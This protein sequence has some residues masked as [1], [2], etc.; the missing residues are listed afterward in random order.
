MLLIRRL[1]LGAAL[2]AVL[3]A[4]STSITI[5][6]LPAPGSTVRTTLTQDLHFDVVAPALPTPILLEGSTFARFVLRTG[7][8]DSLGGMLADLTYDTLATSITMNGNPMGQP[9]QV[10]GQHITA[11]YD[12]AGR[13]VDLT[14]P[15][16]MERYLGNIRQLQS[17]AMSSLP[18]G[19]LSVGDS[20][21]TLFQTP[22]PLDIGM[23]AGDSVA[24]DGTVIHRLRA[25]RR[26]SGQVIAVFDQLVQGTVNREVTMPMLGTAHVTL[27]MTGNGVLEIDV[28]NSLVRSGTTDSRIEATMDLGAGGTVTINGSI[29]MT[30]R[31][32]ALP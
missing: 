11:R 14:V 7:P 5:P 6:K 28:L 29:R 10:T 27:S 31:A 32:S 26:D 18:R 9:A 20:I 3:S 30:S 24:I 1:L 8:L 2:P 17:A 13:L 12:S 16:E 25:I 23:G 22:I 19:S 15:P 21:V 4:Q